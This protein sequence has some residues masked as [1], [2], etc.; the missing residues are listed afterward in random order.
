MVSVEKWKEHFKRLTNHLHSPE[1]V[2]LV[3]QLL[4][5]GGVK[6]MHKGK[7]SISKKVCRKGKKS[8]AKKKKKTSK[9]TNKKKK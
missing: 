1:D 7:G 5:G 2:Y 4:K 9:K 6:K 3:N 8:K